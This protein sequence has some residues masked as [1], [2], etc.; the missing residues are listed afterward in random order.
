P[1][2]SPSFRLSREE[3]YQLL[4]HILLQ[5]RALLPNEIPR[6][7][8]RSELSSIRLCLPNLF[9]RS[10]LNVNRSSVWT[11]RWKTVLCWGRGVL[12]Y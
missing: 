10:K 12:S 9:L 11:K 6:R 1:L 5:S 3:F 7:M 2:R 4:S 8:L